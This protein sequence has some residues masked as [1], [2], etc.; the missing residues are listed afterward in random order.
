MV[1]GSLS[2]VFLVCPYPLRDKELEYFVIEED[3]AYFSSKETN[4]RG[5]GRDAVSD[6]QN[7]NSPS[8]QFH[9]KMRYI[10]TWLSLER[11]K[12]VR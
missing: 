3:F 4:R 9:Q 10:L 12:G 11:E 1:L 2:L 5:N 6:A 8:I 7:F